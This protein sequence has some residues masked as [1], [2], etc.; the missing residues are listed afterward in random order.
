MAISHS[1]AHET[2]TKVS[3]KI[4]RVARLPAKA[5]ADAEN[6]EEQPQWKPGPRSR[7]CALITIILQ[8]KD[9][10][11]EHKTRNELVK[12]HACF[13]HRVLRV[14]AKDCGCCCLDGRH[15]ADVAAAFE[16]VDA[17][18]IVD[19]DHACCTEAT[20]ELGEEVDWE[21]SPW[22]FAQDAVGERD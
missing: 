20:E 2:W 22:E 4:D 3:N 18:D 9:D 1:V 5:S 16:G 11:H 15:G 7:K 14:S 8:R 17:V 21:A 6:E 13:G 19:V 12:E 10:E